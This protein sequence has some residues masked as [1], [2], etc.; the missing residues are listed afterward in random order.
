MAELLTSIT[1]RNFVLRFK[2][3]YRKTFKSLIN[4]LFIAS[5][6]DVPGVGVDAL[7]DVD[8]CCEF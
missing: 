7:L 1:L 2:V 6:V 4:E 3:Y 5:G 8:A